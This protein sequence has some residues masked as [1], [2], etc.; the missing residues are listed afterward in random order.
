MLTH[1]RAEFEANRG[2]DKKDVQLI[3]HLLRKGA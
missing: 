3:E 2:V 1:Y